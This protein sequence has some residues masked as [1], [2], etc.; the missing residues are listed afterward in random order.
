MPAWMKLTAYDRAKVLK[1]TADLMR[2]RADAIARTL[3]ME[4][5]KPRGRGQ[6]GG[7]ALGRHLR[8]VRRGRQTGLRP[9]DSELVAGQTAR[10]HQASRRRRRRHQ[11]VEFPDHAAIAQDRPGPGGRLHHRL[12]AG[13]PDAA[14]PD[15]GLRVPDRRRAAAGRRQPGHGSGSGNRRRVPGKPDL[16]QDQLHRLDRGGQAT[17]EAAVPTR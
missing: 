13:Q 4:Q 1:K 7:A 8:M 17:D 16:P 14:V 11:P 9:G 3:T 10:H 5:G 2:E 15:P 12:Q 6:G